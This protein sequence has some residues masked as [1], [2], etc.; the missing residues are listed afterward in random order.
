M[1][2][3]SILKF[4]HVLSVVFWIGGLAALAFATWRVAKE[5]NRAVLTAVLR[6]SVSYGRIVVGAAAGIVLLSG[7]AMVGIGHVGFRT[8]WVWFG[9]GGV[10]V[11]GFIGGFLIRKRAAE[12]L[13]LASASG[14][15]VALVAAARRL[16][17]TQLVYLILLAI[18]IAS[19]VLKP[20]L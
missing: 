8:F 5:R 15:D 14:N 16:W 13:Q 12:L 9:Y 19:M 18:V 10:L 6:Q 1:N 7:L 4:L 11:H 20:T 17:N 3:Y 2:A